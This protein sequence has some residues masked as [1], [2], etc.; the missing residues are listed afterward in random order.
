[1]KLVHFPWIIGFASAAVFSAAHAEPA[2]G[3]TVTA[4]LTATTV[5]VAA[6]VVVLAHEAFAKKPF[7]P[8]GE[9]KKACSWV[10]KKLFGGRSS[11]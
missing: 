5:A 7:G 10:A 8:S 2:A 11:C 4:P 1:M 6:P 3:V 9:G